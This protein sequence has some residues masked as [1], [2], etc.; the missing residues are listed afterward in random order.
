MHVCTQIRYQVFSCCI[1]GVSLSKIWRQKFIPIFWTKWSFYFSTL[2]R[3][4]LLSAFYVHIHMHIYTSYTFW[5]LSTII[6]LST[7]N[8]QYMHTNIILINAVFLRNAL[9][10]YYECDKVRTTY[11]S[12]DT[13]LDQGPFPD[14]ICIQHWR[15]SPRKLAVTALSMFTWKGRK[16]TD[17]S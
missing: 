1:S 2:G 4:C 5:Q 13:S 7:L 15:L 6:W 12:L 14:W 3:K 8:H 16:V 11:S 10:Y 9:A 17:F